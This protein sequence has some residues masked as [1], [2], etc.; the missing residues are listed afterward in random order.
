MRATRDTT[1]STSGV[2]MARVTSS[3]A[4]RT[5]CSPSWERPNDTGSPEAMA[6]TPA[7]SAGST[8]VLSARHATA[9][10]MAPVSR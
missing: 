7:S 10:Y 6:M 8:P 3:P 9:R 1:A 5:V 4:M 2:R